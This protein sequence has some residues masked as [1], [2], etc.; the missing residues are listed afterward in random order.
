MSRLPSTGFGSSQKDPVGRTHPWQNAFSGKKAWA[1][2]FV[3][4][5]W[6]LFGGLC[7]A[8]WVGRMILGLGKP[9]LIWMPPL[10]CYLKL[11]LW[12]ART[13]REL[14]NGIPLLSC[15]PILSLVLQVALDGAQRNQPSLGQQMVLDWREGG[16]DQF[17]KAVLSEMLQGGNFRFT[18]NPERKDEAFQAS[19]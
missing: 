12:D 19:S 6:C 13:K 4:Q 3:I 8:L 7:L 11:C 17:S 18:R 1:R 10:Y 9:E 15:K 5:G 14:G 16:G 2:H